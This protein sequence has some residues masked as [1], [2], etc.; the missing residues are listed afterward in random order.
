MPALAEDARHEAR[1]AVELTDIVHF[2][3]DD[4]VIRRASRSQRRARL[5]WRFITEWLVIHDPQ[6]LQKEEATC[7]CNDN[8]NYY[9]SEW[10]LT[11]VENNW[12]PLGNDRHTRAT[13][14][15]LGRLFRDNGTLPIPNSAA[16]DR[17]LEAIRV[18]RFDLMRES[19]AVDDQ[20]RVSV[21]NKLMEI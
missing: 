5:F 18:S 1:E 20:A 3:G 12:V 21:D 7:T 9:Q 19:M 10:L 4:S 17:L 8:H 11:V 6:G 15:S 2:R 14:Q 16:V 13:A